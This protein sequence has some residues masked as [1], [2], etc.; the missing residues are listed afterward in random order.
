ML[1]GR[2]DDP[3]HVRCVVPTEETGP[4]CARRNSLL[5]GNE[6]NV[7][8]LTEKRGEAKVRNF[9]LLVGMMLMTSLSAPA[10]PVADA[11]AI[12]NMGQQNDTVITTKK[13]RTT[14][15][16]PCP[17]DPARGGRTGLCSPAVRAVRSITEPAVQPDTVSHRPAPP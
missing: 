1:G 9:I 11:A 7:V 4:R 10:G 15:T 12:G 6:R 2:V 17:N 13:P 14:D 5:A 16:A 8:R 3:R